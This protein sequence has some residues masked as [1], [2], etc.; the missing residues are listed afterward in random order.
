ME[1]HVGAFRDFKKIIRQQEKEIQSFYQ[2][3]CDFMQQQRFTDAETYLYKIKTIKSN[4]PVWMY[5]LGNV[6]RMQAQ[7]TL[8]YHWY[9][10]AA[11][12]NHAPSFYHLGLIEFKRHN[13]TLA[14][15][16]LKSAVMHGHTEAYITLGQ[17]FLNQYHLNAAIY[18]FTQAKAYQHLDAYLPLAQA[19][20]LQKRYDVAHELLAT[21]YQLNIT[22]TAHYLGNVYCQQRALKQAKDWYTY[23]FQT[24]FNLSSLEQL[25]QI[26]CTEQQIILGEK[27]I[28]LAH[29]LDEETVL[30][31]EQH[32][33]LGSITGDETQ[34]YAH[35]KLR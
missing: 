15:H 26:L 19:Y 25:G 34:L 17:I 13:Y 24:E 20:S 5:G 33:L 12:L 21:A 22:D 4:D 16:Y 1:F 2:I 8:A 35:F 23:S 9:M 3:A 31:D 28:Q 27:I 14:E 29:L 11:E 32:A 18:Y 30:T 10:Q 6:Y 7:H